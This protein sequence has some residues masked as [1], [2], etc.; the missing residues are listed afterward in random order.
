[1]KHEIIHL[2]EKYPFLGENGCDP[3]V[4]MYLPY[5]MTEMHR[6]DKKRPCMIVCPGGG[7]SMCSQRESEPI[8][9]HFLPQGFNVF[10]ITYSVAPHRFPTQL[11]EVAALIELIYEN[12]DNWNCNTEKL[13]I[14]GFSAG[15]HLAAHYT[16]A[17]NCKEVR[18]VFPESKPVNASL[19]C[20]PVITADPAYS[21]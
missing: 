3:T 6:Q 7:Y 14:I 9:L 12:A 21:H 8:A 10:V 15:G 19:L 5:N 1:M 18:Q 13:A 16:T 2:K 20:Y 17:Y 4:E 11:R